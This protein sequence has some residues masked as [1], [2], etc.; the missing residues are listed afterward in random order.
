MEKGEI[1]VKPSRFKDVTVNENFILALVF[2][3]F[4]LSLFGVIIWRQL[5]GT[6]ALFLIIGHTSAWIELVAIHYFR[7]RKPPEAAAK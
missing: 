7:R 1:T 3:V 4:T 2:I 6:E 5:G